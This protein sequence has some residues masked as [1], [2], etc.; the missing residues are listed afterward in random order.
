[1]VSSGAFIKR[2]ILVLG[3]TNNDLVNNI[4]IINYIC[5]INDRYKHSL[6]LTVKRI[7]FKIFN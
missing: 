5:Y 1:M 7:F 4:I 6:F 3:I 2:A